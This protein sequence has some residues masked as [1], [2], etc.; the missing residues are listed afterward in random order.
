MVA[1]YVMKLNNDREIKIETS[2]TYEKEIES[3]DI[4]FFRIISCK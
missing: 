2:S 4:R 3:E 1:G